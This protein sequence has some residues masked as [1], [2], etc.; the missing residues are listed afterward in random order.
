MSSDEDVGHV[1]LSFAII[2][3]TPPVNFFISPPIGQ[4]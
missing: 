1:M 4:Y 2:L 3:P